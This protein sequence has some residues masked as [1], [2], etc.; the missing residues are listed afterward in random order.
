M[1]EVVAGVA[2]LLGNG[3]ILM[4]LFKKMV[5]DIECVKDETDQVRLNY[6]EKFVDVKEVINANHL[7]IVQRMTKLETLLINKDKR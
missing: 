3:G 4:W 2:V 1:V 6:L 5:R 7:D